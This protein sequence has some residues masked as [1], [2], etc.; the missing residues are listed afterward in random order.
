LGGTAR[1]CGA[2]V[3]GLAEVAM[4]SYEPCRM[5]GLARKGLVLMGG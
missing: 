4:S 3:N 5:Y 2:V 1:G